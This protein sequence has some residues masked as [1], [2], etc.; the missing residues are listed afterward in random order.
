MQTKPYKSTIGVGIIGLGVRGVYCIARNMAEHFE[1]TGFEITAL[2]DRNSQ[3]MAETEV[4]L[5]QRY[6]AQG[7]EIA[8]KL[9]EDGLDLI[10][11]PDVELVVITSITDTHR[12][13]AVPAL[14]V[15]ETEE[16]EL[17]RSHDELT[18]GRRHGATG[19]FERPC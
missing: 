4:A 3:R 18:A 7:V 16:D 1:E 13:F 2:C 8:P 5:K 14:E 19:D 10:A 17:H 6:A 9:Y 15:G 12:Q 11:D